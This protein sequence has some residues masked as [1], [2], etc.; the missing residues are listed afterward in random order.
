M[1]RLIRNPDLTVDRRNLASWNG[2]ERRRASFR[3]LPSLHRRGLTLRARAILPLRDS[4]DGR[5]G[6]LA[7]VR[8]LTSAPEFSGMVVVHGDRVTFEAYA[9]DF[10]GDQVHSIQSITKSITHLLCGRLLDEGLL[11]PRAQIG[12]Y[13]PEIG[14]GYASATVQQAL[15]MDLSNNFE[16]D[17]TAPYSPPPA[18]GAPVG[19]GR[20]EIAMGWRLPPE[21]EEDFGVRAF[22]AALTSDDTQNRT[23]TTLYK[24]ANT[25]V[26]GWIAERVSGRPLAAFLEQVVD[27]AGIEGAFYVSLDCEMVPVLSGG[28]AMTARD[29]AR[30]GLIFARGARGANG[31]PFGSA[32]FLAD[33]LSG[34]GTCYFERGGRIRYRNQLFTAGSWV[35]HA[36]YAG[37]FMMAD[38]DRQMAAAFFS[39]LETTHG[40]RDGYF[41]QVIEMLEEVLALP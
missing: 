35:G 37:Q 7:S 33:T 21:G 26:L 41:A 25:D 19:Y 18:P 5:I 32:A 28:G 29:L 22:A 10:S 27:G 16:E 15:D 6:A 9:P 34:R 11:D 12:A 1:M 40:D 31:A 39:V 14:S 30:Y 3:R 13:L 8:S 17:Y 24:S 36:G 20:E 38:T 4:I 2:P 23:G